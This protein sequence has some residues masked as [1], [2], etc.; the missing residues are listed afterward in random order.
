MMVT[1]DSMGPILQLFLARFSNFLLRKFVECRYYTNF[2]WPYFRTAG[3]YGHM[4]GHTAI[5]IANTDL[6]FT[7]SQLMDDYDSMGPC[8]QLS[9]ARF[10]NCCPNWRS[11]DFEVRETLISPEFTAFYLG[12]GRG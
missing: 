9:R 1:H 8:L 2:K 3:G 5:R 6:T 11:R 12:A 7:S 10:L 4:V